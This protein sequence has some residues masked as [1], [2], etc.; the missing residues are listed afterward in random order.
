M[1]ETKFTPGLPAVRCGS[2]GWSSCICGYDA[3]NNERDAN[4]DCPAHYP[5]SPVR[6]FPSK[7]DLATTFPRFNITDAL[8]GK[9][10]IHVADLPKI[11]PY[12]DIFTRAGEHPAIFAW[13]GEWVS[14][15]GEDGWETMNEQLRMLGG[16][17]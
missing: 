10:F 17:K 6:K 2:E 3:R 1:S 5:K 7:Q 4:L 8:A 15:E 11:K 16:A 14:F 9:P 12:T 13:C